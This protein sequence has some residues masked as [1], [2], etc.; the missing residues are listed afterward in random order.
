MQGENIVSY[1]IRKR[2]AFQ[3]R[4]KIAQVLAGG[5]KMDYYQAQ[6]F[7]QQ[8][9]SKY[10]RK[11]ALRQLPMTLALGIPGF[12]L[13]LFLTLNLVLSLYYGRFSANAIYYGFLGL[14]L[15]IGSSLGV[16]RVV[17]KIIEDE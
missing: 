14:A 8:V 10:A 9:E 13:G 6:Q 5:G 1:V 17:S 16:H 15:M 4:D 7:I 11:I 12:F 3:S 2:G